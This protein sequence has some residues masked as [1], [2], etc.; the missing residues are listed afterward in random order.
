MLYEIALDGPDVL[1]KRRPDTTYRL[2]P[3]ARDEFSRPEGTLKFLRGP[4][5]EVNE[6]SLRGS[7]VFDLRLRRE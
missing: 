6:L 1:L 7:R 5:G 2:R 4:S 3:I